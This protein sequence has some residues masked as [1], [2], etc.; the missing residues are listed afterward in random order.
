MGSE[1]KADQTISLYKCVIAG[2]FNNNLDGSDVI[3]DC[4]NKFIQ[5][6]SLKR[7]DDMTFFRCES[8]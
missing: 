5:D 2:D 1:T 3:A 7:C 8:L 4:I 6:Y